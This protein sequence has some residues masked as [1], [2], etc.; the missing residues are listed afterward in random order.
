MG[1]LLL[2]LGSLGGGLCVLVAY[3]M[4]CWAGV[5]TRYIRTYSAVAPIRSMPATSK[6]VIRT[7]KRRRREACITDTI[8]FLTSGET[9]S[10]SGSGSGKYSYFMRGSFFEVGPDDF[11]EVL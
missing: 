4:Y 6:T 9:G 10:R 2:G 3:G 5:S 8:L 7:R 11:D 1:W